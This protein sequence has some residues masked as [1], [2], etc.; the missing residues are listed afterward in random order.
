MKIWNLGRTR[1]IIRALITVVRESISYPYMDFQKSKDIHMDN[2]Y[3]MSVFNYPFKCGYPHW[4][5]SRDVHA[6]TFCNGYPWTI[7]IYKSIS[8]FMDISLQLSKNMDIQLDIQEFLRISMHGLT[9][10]SRSREFV[11][12]SMNDPHVNNMMEISTRS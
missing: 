4:Y 10:D 1:E 12:K 9:M 2:Y 3:W 8:T 5:P 11:K 6:R 7:D